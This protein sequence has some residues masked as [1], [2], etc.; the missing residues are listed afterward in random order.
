MQERDCDAQAPKEA[1]IFKKTEFEVARRIGFPPAPEIPLDRGTNHY[2]LKPVARHEVKHA[3]AAIETRQG[4]AEFSVERQ[5]DTLGYVRPAKTTNAA[6]FQ[7][8][9]MAS[10]VDNHPEGT[11]SDLWQTEVLQYASGG[12]SKQNAFRT[13]ASIVL[14]YS[15]VFWEKLSDIAAFVKKG[16]ENQFKQWTQ[17]AKWELERDKIVKETSR[18]P[19]SGVIFEAKRLQ[20]SI[21]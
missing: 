5:G 3:T 20:S 15:E 11:G 18:L 10:S 16:T 17:R 2:H 14:R 12:V 1:Q 13:A 19:L 6:A 9:A 7:V 4:M 21:A 8:I